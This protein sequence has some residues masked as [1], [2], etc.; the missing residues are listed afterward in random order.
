MIIRSKE[1]EDGRDCS[2]NGRVENCIKLC[3]QNTRNF[4]NPLAGITCYLKYGGWECEEWF[5]VA[6]INGQ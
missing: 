1:E 5:Y 4:E 6:H 2:M 3:G